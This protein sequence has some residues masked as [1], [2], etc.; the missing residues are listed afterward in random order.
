MHDL[1]SYG[2]HQHANA[3]DLLLRDG[4]EI[5]IQH[6][7]IRK[8]TR[9]ERSQQVFPQDVI[10]PPAGQGL[11]LDNP[12][13]PLIRSILSLY[14]RPGSKTHRERLSAASYP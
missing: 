4:Q 13:R 1:P 11:Q 5:F 10:G 2:R 9:F 3:W 8:L 7:K 14:S 12:V 6:N